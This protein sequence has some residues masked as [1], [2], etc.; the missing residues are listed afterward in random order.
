M[1]K[2]DFN[3][4]PKLAINFPLKN[5]TKKQA[6]MGWLLV[7]LLS[8]P[9]IIYEGEKKCVIKCSWDD[10]ERHHIVYAH[11]FMLPIPFLPLHLVNIVIDGKFMASRWY[12]ESNSKGKKK[13]SKKKQNLRKIFFF[14]Y[15]C[16]FYLCVFSKV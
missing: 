3:Q 8:S 14:A 16:G 12:R 5:K 13:V 10:E 2:K 11:L 4:M 1:Y 9:A 6:R 7:L 15:W